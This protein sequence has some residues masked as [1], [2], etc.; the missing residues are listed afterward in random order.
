MRTQFAVQVLD[1]IVQPRLEADSRVL[2]KGDR[3]TALPV[4]LLES[5]QHGL[6][7]RGLEFEML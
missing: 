3:N 5:T 2:G 1:R 4:M 6:L 7:I